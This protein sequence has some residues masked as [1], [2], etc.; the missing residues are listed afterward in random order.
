MGVKSAFYAGSFDLFHN[1]HADVIKHAIKVFDRIIIGVGI[2]SLKTTSLSSFDER[3]KII[4]KYLDKTYM[5]RRKGVWVVTYSS[6]LVVA[7]REHGCEFIVRGLRNHDDFGDEMLLKTTNEKIEETFGVPEEKT[8]E[9]VWIP[10]NIG[11]SST[12]LKQ[13]IYLDDYRWFNLVKEYVP[14]WIWEDIKTI[15][16]RAREKKGLK[17]DYD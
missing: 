3:I 2:N 14:M 7:A 13:L 9:T 17:V 16:A 10:T 12:L 4:N 1:G 15:A 8:L 5:H 11:T 6:P